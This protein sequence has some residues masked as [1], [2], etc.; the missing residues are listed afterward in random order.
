MFSDYKYKKFTYKMYKYMYVCLYYI[1]SLSNLIF[2][3]FIIL[4]VCVFLSI[5]TYIT[6]MHEPLKIKQGTGFSGTGVSGSFESPYG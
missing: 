4:R 6:C 2:K 3:I 5:C 1:Y